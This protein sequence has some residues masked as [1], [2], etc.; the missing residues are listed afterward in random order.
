MIYTVTLNPAVDYVVQLDNFKPGQIN[1]SNFD[2]KEAGGKGI[3]VSRVLNRFNTSS[4]ALGFIGGFT[5]TFIADYLS[6]A[7]ISHDFIQ[8]EEDTRINVKLKS[9]NEESEVNGRSPEITDNAYSQFSAKLKGLSSEDIVVLAGSLPSS[10]PKDTYRSLV[11][12]LNAQGVTAILDTSGEALAEAIKAGP[13]FIKPNNFELAEL[14]GEEVKTDQDIIRLAKRLHEENNVDHVLVS[15]AK[16]G[17]IYVGEAGVLK[18]SAPKGKAIHSVGAG[19]SAVAGFIY[20]WQETKN[21]EEAAKYAVASGSA[22]AFSKTLC[23]KEEVENLL[24]EVHV[25]KI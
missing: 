21:A 4:T 11:D 9:G 14:F 23:T 5:G 24:K 15:M 1:R 19:D 13:A 6:E 25:T 8:L 16:E 20:K 2:Y 22:T 10:L 12:M 18:L 3:N 17:A 7:N